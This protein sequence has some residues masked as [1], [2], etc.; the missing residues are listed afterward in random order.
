MPQVEVIKLRNVIQKSR[1]ENTADV[2]FVLSNL[3]KLL[4]QKLAQ[5]KI[6]ELE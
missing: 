4:K 2:D 3:Q 5:G 6:I 1:I